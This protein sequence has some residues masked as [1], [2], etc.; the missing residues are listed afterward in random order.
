MPA[1]PPPREKYHRDLPV[2]SGELSEAIREGAG[3]ERDRREREKG[4]RVCSRKG[5]ERLLRMGKGG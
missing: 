1:P 3:R 4:R 2:L 5:Q